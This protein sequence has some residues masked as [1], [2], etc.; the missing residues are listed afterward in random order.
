VTMLD[1]RRRRVRDR[2][3]AAR[4]PGIA[5]C[6]ADLADE[7]RVIEAARVVF[8]DGRGSDAVELLELA[9]EEN[10][11]QQGPWLAR[12]EIL[13]LVR[14]VAGFTRTARAFAARHRVEGD[15]WKEVCRLGQALAPAEAL[16][17]GDVAARDFEH[18]GPW[19]HTPNWIRS[20]WDLA[21]EMA[22]AE[23]HNSLRRVREMG[24]RE[25]A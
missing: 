1:A 20:P 19:P 23:F 13:Y 7:D 17:A 6:G 5:A 14:D 18:Y 24:A 12:L 16:F 2:Y 22:A 9:N 21:S 8:E 10:P 11:A 3:I 25:A 15:T 4:F